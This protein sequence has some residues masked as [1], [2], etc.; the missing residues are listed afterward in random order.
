MI[1]VTGANGLLGSFIVRKLYQ[2]GVPFV[3]LKR[4]SSDTSILKDLNEKVE[5]R[6]VDVVDAVAIH[7]ALK[8]VT[9]VIHTAALVSFNPRKF[10]KLFDV[11]VSGTRNIVDACLAL[12][13]RRLLHIS[14]VAALGRQ[15]GQ[16]IV[17]ETNKWIDSPLN[18]A[19]GKSKYQAEL[20][21]Y[22]GQEEGLST[23]C[24]N[25]SVILAPA[26]WNNSS[27]QLFKYV[28][29]ERPF[30]V[31]GFMNYV[32]V[33]DVAEIVF[34]LFNADV[35]NDGFIINAGSISFK[36]FFDIV[37]TRFDRKAPGIK[38]S[39][40]TVKIVAAFEHLRS[41]V[42]AADPLITKET[43]RLAETKFFFDNEKVRNELN[44]EFQSIDSTL[45]WCCEYYLKLNG[46]KNE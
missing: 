20:E 24:I 32:D 45:D 7:E 3:A 40:S 44:F 5:W 26:N 46:A 43:A 34:Q 37:A 42:T 13:I 12:G 29:R 18:T 17:D 39:K 19:Y 38:L 4:K 27:A 22:R 14:S 21:V 31:D 25:P 11:N 10:N 35:E 6:D 15:K 36:S 41:I 33:R 8:D 9:G 2:E 23:V 30:Y 28:W 16:G 1:A